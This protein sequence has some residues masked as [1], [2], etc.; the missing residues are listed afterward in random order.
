MGFF[1]GRVAFARFRVRGR[2]VRQF[3]PEQLE[4]LAA[5]AAGTQRLAS[6]DGV[7]VGWTAGHHVLDTGF[8]LAKNVVNDALFCCFRVDAEKP[9]SDL[10]RAYSAIELAALVAH[11]PSGRPSARQKREARD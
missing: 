11:N 2:A 10:F 3:G 7:E 5:H 4:R 9:P 1:S 6:A 8:D